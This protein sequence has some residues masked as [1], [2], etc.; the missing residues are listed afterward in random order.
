MDLEPLIR[1]GGALIFAWFWP[2]CARPLLIAA[3]ARPPAT[4]LVLVLTL[5]A[6][7]VWSAGAVVRFID[8]PSRILY[9]LEVASGVAWVL[10]VGVGYLTGYRNLVHA[11]GGAAP[12][13]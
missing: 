9:W 2:H 12:E 1:A 7:G 3:R 10:V 4:T 5:V 6:V 8:H 11:T 13:A